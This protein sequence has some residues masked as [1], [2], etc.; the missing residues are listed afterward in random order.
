[1]KNIYL[2]VICTALYVDEVQIFCMPGLDPLDVRDRWNFN[3]LLVKG[4]DNFV[5][6]NV[7]YIGAGIER[8]L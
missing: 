1:M 2:P 3:Y 6:E 4:L 8:N 7:G 5:C